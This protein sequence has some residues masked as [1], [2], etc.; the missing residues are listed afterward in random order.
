[1]RIGNDW[2]QALDQDILAFRAT[3]GSLSM[4]PAQ[5]LDTELVLTLFAD[6]LPEEDPAQAWALLNGYAF[7]A[8][9]ALPISARR[10]ISIARQRL[11]EPLG[12]GAWARRL[13]QYA[14]LPDPYPLYR[15]L[16]RRVVMQ[17]TMVAP[18]RLQAI[19]AALQ[20]PPP[21]K[22][23]APRYAPA[24]RY[25]FYLD[26]IP[27]EVEISAEAA[28]VAERPVLALATPAKPVR[29]PL[30]ITF[31]ALRETACRMDRL[32][33][34]YW[35]AR[36]REVEL[37]LV[38]ATGLVAT[39][40]LTVNGV[41]HLLGMVGS[42]KSTLLTV[43]AAHLA[44]QDPPLRIVIVQSDVAGLLQLQATFEALGLSAVPL[45]GRSTRV[46]HLNRLH[47]FEAQANSPSLAGD[48]PGYAMLSTVCALD[49]LRRDVAPI[50]PGSEPCNALYPLDDAETLN[51]F[52]CPFLKAC[53]VH[54]PTRR[55]ARAPIWLATPASL[56]ASR[57]QP[58]LVEE[59][60]RYLELVVRYADI[61]L[62][63]EAD[64]I[65]TQFDDRFAPT[66][67]LVGRDGGWLDR[68]GAQVSR[69]MYRPGRPMVA[70][71][72]ALDRWQALHN[73]VQRAVDSLYRTLREDEAAR[74]WLGESYFSG[75]RLLQRVEK[76]MRDAGG[77]MS[78][79]AEARNAFR[80]RVLRSGR[81]SIESSASAWVE[82]VQTEI[83]NHESAPALAVLRRW[84]H[85]VAASPQILDRLAERLLLALVVT[86]LD[87]TLMDM[88]A[89]WSTANEWLDLDRGSGGLF[90]KLSDSLVRLT[91]EGPM[92]A[93]LGFQYYDVD[94][95]GDGSLRFFHV[96]GVGR[97][98]LQSLHDAL[99]LSDGQAGPHVILTSGTSWSPGSWRYHLDVPPG[100]VLLPARRERGATVACFFD[101]IPDPD[102]VRGHPLYVSGRKQVA[103]RMRN[104]QE[105]VRALARRDTYTLSAFDREFAEIEDPE[106]RRILLVVGSYE[107]A[108][109]VARALK[110][111]LATPGSEP[112]DD[113]VLA[114]IP[115][116]RGEGELV[117]QTPEGKILR[118]L[119]ARF[120][121]GPARFLVAPLQAIERGHNILVPDSQKAAIG[122]VYFL[123]RPV[124][125][126][127]DL[128]TAVHKMNAWALRQIPLLT[129]DRIGD[130]GL[131]LRQEAAARWDKVLQEQETYRHAS[132]RRALVATQLVL[133]WQTI[134]RLLRGGVQ[135]RVHFVDGKWAEGSAGLLDQTMADT[136]A[137]SMLLGFEALLNEAL[138]DPDPARRQIA[139]TLYGPFAEALG[140]TENIHRAPDWDDPRHL[141]SKEDFSHDQ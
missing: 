22:R 127:G 74:E 115:D 56:L 93:V 133:V 40:A 72:P 124:P 39:D 109:E 59:E 64:L 32:V 99:L 105:M 51:A 98:L 89:E 50:P 110:E 6:Y 128:H 28:R 58:P 3:Y 83:Y 65:Q 11:P 37:C 117:W 103:E 78:R 116:R 113:Q 44:W 104:L 122:S 35:E 85:G 31:A 36:L 73:T 90:Q 79:F 69:Q 16:N 12:R 9:R 20:T 49:G 106:R 60:Q 138:I 47:V 53:P 70:K 38:S 15:I 8:I 24:G 86:V 4:S 68:L 101:P 111:A 27:H 97:L 55:L 112:S 102:N 43:L 18:D 46:S 140:N 76:E 17:S 88:I 7:P 114:L 67:V 91:P 120:G 62:V 23:R 119:L 100:A 77:T 66:E 130:A 108:E 1:M 26:R 134:G 63:D 41:L 95:S 81:I 121:E 107:Q 123:T 33:A 131:A 52:D 75:E 45:V 87:E 126:P 96:R 84:L 136:A 25:R 125:I 5:L 21:W 71:T 132:D 10:A 135:A 29:A 141:R 42:G 139:Q 2:R 19:R 118:S 80:H 34:A 30:T 54:E 137:T 129:K 57:P 94:S 48:H 14:E 61:V 13:A 82:A 92:G